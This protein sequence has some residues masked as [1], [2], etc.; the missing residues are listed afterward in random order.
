[1]IL[2]LLVLHLIGA[3][4]WVGGHLILALGILPQALRE[5]SAK[6]ILDFEARFKMLGHSALAIQLITGIEL[7]RRLQPKMGAWF[8]FETPLDRTIFAKLVVLTLTLI[9][10]IHMKK[11]VMPGAGEDPKKLAMHIRVVTLLALLL[12]VFGASFKNGMFL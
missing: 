3:S 7:A 8:S 4:L 10:A 9:L 2:T 12:L 11:K 1:M 5:G 6:R